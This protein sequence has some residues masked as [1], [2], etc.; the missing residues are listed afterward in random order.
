V[1]EAVSADLAA[2][3]AEHYAAVFRYA[4]R[5]SG[6][7]ADAEDLAQQVFL[8]AQRKFDQLRG[9]DTARAWLFAILRNCFLAS[10]RQAQPQ[11]L[12]TELHWDELPEDAAPPTAIDSEL[13]QQALNALPDEYRVV[14]LMYYFEECA[15]REMAEQLAIPV[16]TV[17]SRLSRAKAALR[18]GLWGTRLKAM[19]A[20]GN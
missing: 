13:L 15:Y 20:S 14:V 17:M 1:N 18:A 12:G 19:L 5:L 9:P 4:Y 2:L 7:N 8:A 3:V 11:A 16:G 6:N 10:R